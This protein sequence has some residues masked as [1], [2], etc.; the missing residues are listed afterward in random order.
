VLETGGT[1]SSV[2]FA[3]E[4]ATWLGSVV[5]VTTGPSPVHLTPFLLKEI[6][7]TGARGGH[8]YYPEAI[9]LV[10]DRSVDVSRMITHRFPFEQLGEAFEFTLAN[11]GEAVRVV[12]QH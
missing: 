1:D 4:A 11:P 8:G 6:R 2:A 10:A 3:I 7:L 12:I 5:I 9:R